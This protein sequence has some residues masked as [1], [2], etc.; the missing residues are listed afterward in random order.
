MKMFVTRF[1]FS[2]KV[3]ITGDITQTDLP[4]YTRSGLKEAIKVLD[5]I[6]GITVR[7]LTAKDVVR[8]P[9]VQKIID[10]YDKFERAR[11]LKEEKRKK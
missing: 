1:G 3:V 5:G 6:E 8:H 11:Q 7:Y 4:A 10:A 9:L 2:S